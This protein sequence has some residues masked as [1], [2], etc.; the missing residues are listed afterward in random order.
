MCGLVDV[1]TVPL[2]SLTR[3]FRYTN[4]TAYSGRSAQINLDKR[5]WRQQNSWRGAVHFQ[6][7]TPKFYVSRVIFAMNGE[8]MYY[9]TLK[10]MF[11]GEP[12]SDLS[13]N[14]DIDHRGV[15]IWIYETNL[16]FTMEID[17]YFVGRRSWYCVIW[18]HAC[19]YFDIKRHT[20]QKYLIATSNWRWSCIFI[21]G[22]S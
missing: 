5:S 22:E 16:E 11:Y 6:S 18:H 9:K 14:M 3:K 12:P 15:L 7:E 8:L 21:V 2:L 19:S 1:L 10:R 17:Q 20:L 4:T 13:W